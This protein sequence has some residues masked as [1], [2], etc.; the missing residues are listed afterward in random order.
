[1]KPVIQEEL[2]GCGIA[3]V[4]ALAGITY[5]QAKS[6][7]NRLGIFAEDQQLWSETHHI[8]TLL[9]HFG[10][11]ASPAESPFQSWGSLPSLALLSTKWHL[12]YGR[13]FWHW[14]I[15]WRGHQGAV[16]LDSKKTLQHNVRTD[17]WRIK[18]KW[19][20]EVHRAQ[21]DAPGDAPKAARP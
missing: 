9:L 14:A 19:F 6:I 1:V 12:E 4:A 16:I 17:F 11:Q 15:F 3:S 21:Q 7:A 2:T 13:P 10:L 18:P 8:R 5:Q 20:I